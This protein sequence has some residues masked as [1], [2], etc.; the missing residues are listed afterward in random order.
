MR[1][2]V[3]ATAALA[4]MCGSAFAADDMNKPMTKDGMTN[5]TMNK[6]GGSM[7]TPMN[8][9]QKAATTGMSN[10]GM[11]N[12]GMKSGMSKDNMTKDG[13]KKDGMSK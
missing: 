11:K 7:G 6:N 13:M 2:I 4:L 8:D 3:F 10:D 9:G 12:D 1:K 5:G